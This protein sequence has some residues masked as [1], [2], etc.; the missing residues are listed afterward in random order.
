MTKQ[1]L[2]VA[3]AY[4]TGVSQPGVLKVI[5]ALSD[6]VKKQVTKGGDVTLRG[7]GTFQTKTRKEKVGRNISLGQPVV[8]PEHRIPYFKPAAEFKISV[9]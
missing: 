2:V 8:I 4:R 9:K 6:E 1:E 5:E 3:I 7:F